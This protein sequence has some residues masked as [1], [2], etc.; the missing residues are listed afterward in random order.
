MVVNIL[1]RIFLSI[2]VDAA[3]LGITIFYPITNVSTWLLISF[4]LSLLSNIMLLGLTLMS[5]SQ[6]YEPEIPRITPDTNLWLLIYFALQ[7]SI[8]IWGTGMMYRCVLMMEDNI[9]PTVSWVSI[10]IRW[11]NLM[12]MYGAYQQLQSYS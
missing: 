11:L 4:S 1:N 3:S 10:T 12:W 5:G 2:I 6:P 9:I 8:I 7:V